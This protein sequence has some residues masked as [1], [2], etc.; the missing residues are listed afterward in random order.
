MKAVRQTHSLTAAD[1]NDLG[2]LWLF[3]AYVR[4]GIGT[5][6]E[7]IALLPRAQTMQPIVRGR[8]CCGFLEGADILHL[9]SG[10]DV[11]RSQVPP[12]IYSTILL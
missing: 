12:Q 10:I 6:G 3:T 4:L 9:L 5:H 8:E 11:I 1:L 7:G 2:Q